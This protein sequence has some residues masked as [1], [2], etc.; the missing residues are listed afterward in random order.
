MKHF[1]DFYACVYVRDFPVQTLLRLHPDLRNK[2]CVVTEGK[3]PLERVISLNDQ[4]RRK[5]ANISMTRVELDSLPMVTILQRSHPEEETAKSLLL[6]CAWS[7][8]PR[9]E[10]A[11][12]GDS[13]LMVIDITGTEKLQGK[14]ESLIASLKKSIAVLSFDC[15]I[16]VSGNYH[17]SMQFARSIA[18]TYGT[19]VVPLAKTQSSLASLPI[20]VLDLAQNHAQLFRMWGI[21]SLGM[22]AE[23]PELDVIA[24]LGQEG[25]HL[26]QLAKGTREHYFRPVEP[27]CAFSE[28]LELDTPVFLLDSLL[29]VINTLL[30][31]LIL[32]ISQSILAIRSIHI[33]LTLEGGTLHQRTVNP[34]LPTNDRALWIK[35]IY[36]D[37]E[38]HAP[39]A[40]I[41]AARLT[42]IPGI[43][44]KIQRGLFSPQ[45]PEPDRLAVTLARIRSIVGED[46]VGCAQILDSQRIDAFQMNA[47]QV[48]SESC[49]KASP[50][51]VRLAMRQLR[52]PD[53][54][55]VKLLDNAPDI[56]SFRNTKY[57][58]EHAYGPWRK[59]GDWWNSLQWNMEQW[60]VIASNMEGSRVCCSIIHHRDGNHWLMAALYD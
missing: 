44:S 2:P 42:A 9:V 34:A 41:L 3:P 13:Y 23:L 27:T 57:I 43:T 49:H 25:K 19:C 11:N 28:Y 18:S 60:D 58:V 52:P 29:F 45:S 5:E 54:I 12:A 8:S 1:P 48:S 50:P 22:L 26:L 38:D 40:S 36:L 55:E 16:A 33:T 7:F 14:P 39:N 6:E 47:F 56:F 21:H 31:Q 15:S 37:L 4:A 59:S 30:D 46:S 24:R 35:L 20:S 53:L 51:S 32:R 10:E 17:A